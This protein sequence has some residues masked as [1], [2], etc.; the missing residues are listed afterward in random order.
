MSQALPKVTIVTPTYNR[1]DLLP[2]TIDSILA[3]D[4]PNLEYIILDDGSTDDTETVVR[5]YLEKYPDIIRYDAHAN[6]GEAATVNKAW[7]MAQGDFLMVVCSDDPQPSKKLV[8]RCVEM[9]AEKPQAV[10]VYPDWHMV[11]ND[12]KPVMTFKLGDWDL[13]YMVRNVHC[14][15]GPGALINRRKLHNKIPYLRN[16]AFKYVSDYECWL[17]IGLEGE[18]VHLPEFH[19]AWRNHDNA[20]T[21]Q[22][23]GIRIAT[24]QKRLFDYY[25]AEMELPLNLRNEEK[26]VKSYLNMVVAKYTVRTNPWRAFKLVF[27]AFFLSPRAFVGRN[28]NTA[29]AGMKKVL[30]LIRRISKT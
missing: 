6:M 2:Q 19:A 30:R 5:P 17:R 4:Y 10:V 11:D 3:Q 1:A 25:F 24:E 20:T 7:D 14:F 22:N 28:W 27:E 8:K 15:I 9:F 18:F 16:P 26:H 12:L 21:V 29:K 23:V 13:E